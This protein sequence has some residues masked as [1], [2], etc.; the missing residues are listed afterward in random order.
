MYSAVLDFWICRSGGTKPT[1]NGA[2]MT[3]P[4][5]PLVQ[6]AA[7]VKYAASISGV[8]LK[9][10]GDAIKMEVLAPIVNGGNGKSE[11]VAGLAATV[12]GKM[13]FVQF[14]VALAGGLAAI[15]VVWI[16]GGGL[17]ASTRNAAGPVRGR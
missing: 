5:T 15:T 12:S 1:W 13:A 11:F 3:T 7:G 2:G 6:S 16:C 4:F 8:T 14:S 10:S 9:K 17:T